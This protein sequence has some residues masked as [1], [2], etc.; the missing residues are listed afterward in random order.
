MSASMQQPLPGRLAE[1]NPFDIGVTFEPR[2]ASPH[3]KN[4]VCRNKP[5]DEAAGEGEFGCVDW[6]QYAARPDKR[7]A[8]Q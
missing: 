4:S 2:K 1:L 8:D 7:N 6:Y 3:A 5:E